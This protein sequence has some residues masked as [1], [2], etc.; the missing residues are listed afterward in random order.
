MNLPTIVVCDNN[1]GQKEAIESLISAQPSLILLG[2]VSRQAASQQTLQQG[3]KVIW[4]ELAPDPQKGLALLNE[5]KEKYPKVH[6]LVSFE[7]LQA[8]LVKTAMQLGAVEYLDMPGASQLLPPAIARINHK[9]QTATTAASS[10][11]QAPLASS[12]PSATQDNLQA[13][14]AGQGSIAQGRVERPANAPVPERVT[15]N[16]L[17]K[18]R[19]LTTEG[20]PNSIFASLPSWLLPSIMLV[21]VLVAVAVLVLMRNH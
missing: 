18:A 2:T 17:R 7:T 11:P 15:N 21:M 4:L 6:Y 10:A 3:I 1:A 8:D 20:D 14:P 9:E 19:T 16:S 13:L 12:R 5:L